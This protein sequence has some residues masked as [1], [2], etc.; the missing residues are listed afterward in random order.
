[1][2]SSPITANGV[3]F[4]CNRCNDC[5][6]TKITAWVS[7]AMAEKATAKNSYLL[8]LTY[9]NSTEENRDGSRVF[10][11]SDIQNFI[12]SVKNAARAFEAE[13][14]GISLRELKYAPS[15]RYIVC[16]ELGARMVGFTGISFFSQNST[17]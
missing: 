1:M 9:E 16:G 4:S 15:V 12:K 13:R 8:A 3:T 6:N 14:L 17:C 5:I 11:Y 2:C 7:R 10:R